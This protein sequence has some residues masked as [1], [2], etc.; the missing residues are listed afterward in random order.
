MQPNSITLPRDVQLMREQMDRLEKKLDLLISIVSGVTAQ[1]TSERHE[2][3]E[4]VRGLLRTGHRL[5]AI[6]EYSSEAGISA[7][8]AEVVLNAWTEASKRP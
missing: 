4:L 1:E 8:H 3:S 7:A 6:K 2:P 5:Q